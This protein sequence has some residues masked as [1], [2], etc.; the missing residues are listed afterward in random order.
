MEGTNHGDVGVGTCCLPWKKSVPYFFSNSS[1]TNFLTGVGDG[2]AGGG[3]TL[4]LS[5]E[6][7]KR[8]AAAKRVRNKVGRVRSIQGE[9]SGKFSYISQVYLITK[10]PPDYFRN[11]S[12]TVAI[13]VA[14][15]NV[16]L[17]QNKMNH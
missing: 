5:D 1:D 11:T 7:R 6:D 10:N 2:V 8:R 16:A 4:L 12:R 3:I 15:P 17:K 13:M 9:K 14:A